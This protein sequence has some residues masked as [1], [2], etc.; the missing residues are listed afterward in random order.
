[1]AAT[2]GARR[3]A[4]L[5][6]AL[7]LREFRGRYRRTVIGPAWALLQPLLT[8]AVFS[9]VRGALDLPAP[10]GD[11]PYAL[12][13]FTALVPWTFFASAQLRCATCIIENRGIVK[14]LP[15]ARGVLPA[16]ALCVALLDFLLAFAVLA[17]MLLWY[18]APLGLALL[19]LPPVSLL[20]AAFCLGLGFAAAALGAFRNDVALGIPFLTQLWL[21]S[22]PVL[23]QLRDVPEHLR[24]IYILNPM[25]GYTEAFRSI[26]IHGESPDPTLLGV[27]AVVTSLVLALGWPLFRSTSRY[28][29]DVL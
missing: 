10:A 29:A 28:F 23:Y 18:N 16:A 14:K 1:V 24:D 13:A 26:L 3:F 6:Q 20:L 9:F 21:L 19:W 27:S 4:T 2:D 25:V 8:L 15:L 11:V 12:F 17:V 22:T 7:V 5:L